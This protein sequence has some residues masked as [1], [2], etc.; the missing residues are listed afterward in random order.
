MPALLDLA[1]VLD[2]RGVP[3]AI[4]GAT[5]LEALGLPRETTDVD[6]FIDDQHRSALNAFRGAGLA[7]AHFSDDVAAAYPAG[8]G[9]NDRIDIIFP[10]IEPAMSG[11]FHAERR[12]LRGVEVPVLPVL[13]LA[14]MK[15][16][17]ARAREHAD[18]L[19]LIDARL[20]SRRAVRSELKRLVK[21]DPVGDGWARRR[22]DPAAALR[23]LEAT[24]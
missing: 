19:R 3:W 5:A 21:L 10:A 11:L 24:S 17:S 16:M 4:G 2:R 7:I 13:A 1:P 23:R 14:A 9:E 22:F 6:V 12:R 20:T 15:L 8:G 18:A